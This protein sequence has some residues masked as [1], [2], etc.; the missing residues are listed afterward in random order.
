MKDWKQYLDQQEARQ[1]NLR[2]AHGWQGQQQQSIK[3][4]RRSAWD[5]SPCNLRRKKNENHIPHI[6]SIMQGSNFRSAQN[7]FWPP[8]SCM[9]N[10]NSH[11]NIPESTRYMLCKIS[12]YLHKHTIF[13]CNLHE[14]CVSLYLY[15]KEK[16]DPSTGMGGSDPPPPKQQNYICANEQKH[17]TQQHT[18]PETNPARGLQNKQT[19]TIDSTIWRTNKWRLTLWDNINFCC[20][21]K[22]SRLFVWNKWKYQRSMVDSI[23]VTSILFKLHIGWLPEF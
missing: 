18:T 10:H 8:E 20:R 2:P 22:S 9:M 16:I 12:L 23:M 6:P 5:S 11:K 7:K 3:H 14:S 21:V 1:R 15:K 19:H 13:F 4:Q 17:T